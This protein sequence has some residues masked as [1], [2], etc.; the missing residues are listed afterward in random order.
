VRP[1]PAWIESLSGR[2]RWLPIAQDTRGV[3]LTRE[4]QHPLAAV[5]APRPKTVKAILVAPSPYQVSDRLRH[6]PPLAAAV[7]KTFAVRLQF[8]NS[9]GRRDR[10]R[11]IQEPRSGDSDHGWRMKSAAIEALA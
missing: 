1:R 6:S 9:L 11:G 8:R 5:G 4:K 2:A 7:P 3:R 10:Y